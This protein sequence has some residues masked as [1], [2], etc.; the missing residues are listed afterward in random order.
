[1]LRKALLATSACA[2]FLSFAPGGA[3]AA[4]DEPPP[5]VLDALQRDLGLT[6]AQARARLAAEADAQRASAALP[7]SLGARW[8]DAASGKLV[9]AVTD[10]ASTIQV[11]A[12][13][14]EARVVRR[15]Q[16]ELAPLTA[17][18]GDLAGDGVP[19]V[20]GW[21]PDPAADGV[22]VRV[23][24][25]ARSA[26]TTAF[27]DRV[28]AFGAP[29]RVVESAAPVQQSGT[30]Q[31]GNPWWPDGESNCSVGFPATDSGGGKHFVTAGHCT[32]DANQ[33]AYG[34]SGLQNRIGTSN[35]GGSRTVNGREGD[36]GVVAV[37]EAGWTLSAAVN[38]WGSA[39]VTVTG[40]V[41]PLV[42]QSVCHSGNTSKWK[43]GAVT[44]VEQTVDYGSTVVEGL[45]TTTACS[46]GGDSGGAW[47]AG[48]KAVGLH[49]GGQ[50]SC[51]PGGAD[52]QSIFQPVDEALRKWG[53]SLVTGTGGGTP[54][55]EA[56]SVPA[57]LRSTATTSSSATLVWNASTDN[58]GVTGYEVYRGGALATTVSTTT[59]TISGLTPDTD[60]VF[61][62][63]AK[64][65]AGNVSAASAPVTVHT[66]PGTPGGGRTFGN[67]TDFPI[68]DHTVAVSPVKVALAGQAGRT[69]TVVVTAT[70]TCAQDL[71]ITL[72]GPSGRAYPLQRYG[73]Y[74]CTAFPSPRTFTASGVGEQATGTWTLRVGDN[75]P[76]DTGVLDAW[77]ITL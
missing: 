60:T 45:A 18:I 44:A 39:P 49:S 2:L 38:T 68:R 19:G 27:L 34:Q 67:D 35:T 72:V 50:S 59:A 74:P 3:A 29:V 64:D 41:E 57:G 6:G 69:P 20:T 75:G 21:G 25:A 1:M 17:S 55:A 32:N 40:S 22:V 51:G 12:R 14:A 54:D 33:A 43:C 63:K 26:A 13:G 15:G 70:H 76:G 30:V 23:D 10:P 65:A 7:K 47:L 8:F 77:T 71:T 52:D 61:S 4:P 62:V 73:G 53:L 37:T 9:V 56:P 36:M 46:M 42:G 31:P 11:R 5:A 66:P 24:R 28:R 16:A 58:V 48:D